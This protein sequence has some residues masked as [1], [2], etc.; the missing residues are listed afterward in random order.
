MI[1]QLLVVLVLHILFVESSNAFFCHPS[2]SAPRSLSLPLAIT[3]LVFPTELFIKTN[4]QKLSPTHDGLLV[5]SV[6]MRS[7][8]Y[9][10]LLLLLPSGRKKSMIYTLD[11]NN[12]EMNWIYILKW[13][14]YLWEK[15]RQEKSSSSGS[16]HIFTWIIHILMWSTKRGQARVLYM[17]MN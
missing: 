5:K 8:N 15:E 12:T 1:R 9:F 3:L 2:F 10:F 17:C 4:K 6:L 13:I 11:G 16:V 7:S 14:E